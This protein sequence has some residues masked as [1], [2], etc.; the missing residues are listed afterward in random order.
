MENPRGLRVL[1]KFKRSIP[2]LVVL[3]ECAGM[4]WCSLEIPSELRDLW[5]LVVLWECAGMFWCSL[6]IPSELKDIW[7]F[8]SSF[9]NALG[10]L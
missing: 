10:M 5:I 9:D 1:L 4:F 2:N 7:N 3:W 8:R 6:E